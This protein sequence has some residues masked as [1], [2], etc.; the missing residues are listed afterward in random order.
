[1]DDL[2]DL[3]DPDSSD[4]SRNS[5]DDDG[6][7]ELVELEDEES[8]DSMHDESEVRISQLTSF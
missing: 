6:P 2:P 7:P 3:V 4:T 1:M 8:A 5:D